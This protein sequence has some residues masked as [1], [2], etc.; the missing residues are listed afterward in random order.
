MIHDKIDLGELALVTF[1]G[2]ITLPMFNAPTSIGGPQ[3]FPLNGPQYTLFLELVV[4]IFWAVTRRIDSLAIALAITAIGFALTATYGAAGDQ[5]HNFWTG[6]PRVFGTYDARVAVFHAQRRF[7]A[8]ASARIAIW[9]WPLLI[10]TGALFYWPHALPKEVGWWWSLLCAPLL[11]F[12]GSRVTLS[13]VPRRIAL[14]LGELS[15][16]IYALH[17]PIFVWI[18]GLYQQ[19]LHRKNYLIGTSLVLPSVLVGA[20]I[21]LRLLDE[22]LRKVL[23]DRTRSRS[24]FGMI[25]ASK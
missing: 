4:N 1:L 3:I 19:V 11:I 5:S 14:L 18:N 23:T 15:Y 17:Y 22:P 13:D 7:P 10:A 24:D 9:F 21:I 12:T 6:F 25:K 16:P 2:L 20:W 8:L